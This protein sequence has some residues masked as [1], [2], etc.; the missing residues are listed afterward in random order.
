MWRGW[1]EV[2]KGNEGKA[3]GGGGV[4]SVRGNEGRAC[5]GGGV[6]VE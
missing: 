1:S 4:R 6:G 2:S 5:G 3:C